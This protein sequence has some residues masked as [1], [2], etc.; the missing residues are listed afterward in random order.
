M[1]LDDACNFLNLNSLSGNHLS[2][3]NPPSLHDLQISPGTLGSLLPVKRLSQSVVASDTIHTNLRLLVWSAADEGGLARLARTYSTHISEISSALN[4]DDAAAYFD[5]LSYTLAYRRTRL[6]WRSFLLAQSVADLANGWSRMS[7]PSR[8]KAVPRLSFVFTGQGAQ[9]PR[10][11]IDLFI[12]PAF[13]DSLRRSEMYLKYVGCK[14]CL[15][16]KSFF[17]FQS[18]RRAMLRSML[19]VAD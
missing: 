18:N 9:Y 17:P 15:V 4:E 12:Y 19:D 5:N 10:M 2:L 7:K 1:I 13:Q 14:W 11:G 16:G 3:Q 8:S 6:N